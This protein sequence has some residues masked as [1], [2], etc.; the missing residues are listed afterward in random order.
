MVAPDVALGPVLWECLDLP[1]NDKYLDK[2]S[3]LSK[4][5]LNSLD[6]LSADYVRTRSERARAPTPIEYNEHVYDLVGV[7]A[8]HQLV[9]RDQRALHMD[10]RIECFPGRAAVIDGVQW[11]VDYLEAIADPLDFAVPPRLILHLRRWTPKGQIHQSVN[12]P[13][14]LRV[15][16]P[17]SRGEH[18]LGPIKHGIV[19]MLPLASRRR[20]H[21]PL[22]PGM[23]FE[24]RLRGRELYGPFQIEAQ[25][26]GQLVARHVLDGSRG[27]KFTVEPHEIAPSYVRVNC[28]DFGGCFDIDAFLYCEDKLRCRATSVKAIKAMRLSTSDRDPMF[29][30][31]PR[32]PL[33]L[34]TN[35]LDHLLIFEKF[36]REC[37]VPS[38]KT[39]Q[40]RRLTILNLSMCDQGDAK[41]VVDALVDF[42]KHNP[43]AMMSAVVS[44]LGPT[45]YQDT[46]ACREYVKLLERNRVHI[47]M[48]TGVDG[49]TRQVVHA[50]AIVIDDR[51]LFSTGAIVDTKPIDKADFSIELPPTAAKVFQIYMQEAIH[52]GVGNERRAHLGSQLASLGVIINDPIASLAYISR[53][54]HTLLRGARRDLLVSVSELV[55]P[56]I[57]KLLARRAANGV[58]VTI[59]VRELDAVSS[60]ILAQA[61]RRY[62]ERLSV[63]DVSWWEPRPHYNA[64][65][66][67]DSLAYLGTSYFWPTQRNMIHQGRSLENGVLLEGEAVKVL[68]EQLEE[69][70]DRAYNY[71]KKGDSDQA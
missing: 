44:K 2:D 45:I 36:I 40:Q 42:R 54:Q 43:D 70:R 12:E 23:T 14:N 5:Q 34:L 19:R 24:A 57:T 35:G 65:I 20:V 60:R 69:L 11:Q 51:T 9:L 1:G 30:T 67:D 49:P 3:P 18:T 6:P 22:A 16:F 55:D 62:G 58:T 29:G 8:H 33:P 48:F 68:R 50:K 10:I 41:I 52:D 28:P 46:P 32:G 4:W 38:P 13:D 59:Q 71:K 64:I 53:A 31:L 61:T 39:P 15:I 27:V 56:K 66:A 47:D 37:T 21:K 63:E 25:K 26:D 7:N 17:G